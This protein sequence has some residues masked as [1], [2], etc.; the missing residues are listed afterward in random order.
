MDQ[1]LYDE[2]GNYIGPDMDD[3]DEEGSDEDGEEP[4][5]EDDEQERDQQGPEVILCS[6]FTMKSLFPVMFYFCCLSGNGG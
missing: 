3:S 1:E 2:F 4:D 5:E 6:L